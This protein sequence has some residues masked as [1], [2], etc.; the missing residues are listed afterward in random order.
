MNS[1][2]RSH[3]ATMTALMLVLA[4]GVAAAAAG[5]GGGSGNAESA[6]IGRWLQ[7]SPDPNMPTTGFSL[8]CGDAYFDSL[9]GAQLIWPEMDFEHGTLTDLAETS[10]NCPVLNYDV[11]GKTATVPAPDPYTTGDPGCVISFTFQDPTTNAAQQ[12][13]F[14]L[15]PGA[16]AAWSFMLLDKVAGEPPQGR[17]V[18]SASVHLA[19]RLASGTIRESNP[20]C[21]YAGMDTYFRLTQP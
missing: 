13:I 18:G 14:I 8:T 12:A 11:N 16:G 21:T 5:C 20:D 7:V 9:G 2:A 10:G 3:A 15:T 19:T 17:L 6:F 1:Q 4:G